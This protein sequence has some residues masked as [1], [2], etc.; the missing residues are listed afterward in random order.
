MCNITNGIAIPAVTV[1][2]FIGNI[3]LHSYAW[4]KYT[5][6]VHDV[7]LK[8]INKK[9]NQHTNKIGIGINL[10]KK[11]KDSDMRIT[12]DEFNGSALKKLN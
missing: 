8:I 4:E 6:R 10:Q 3:L 12:V 1:D 5:L 11:K 2:L 7:N 9:E